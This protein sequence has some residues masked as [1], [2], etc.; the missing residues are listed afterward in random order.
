MFENDNMDKIKT[1]IAG[2]IVTGVSLV[3]ARSW[4]GVIK[5]LVS[6]HVRQIRCKL[7]TNNKEKHKKCLHDQGLMVEFINAG[8]TTLLMAGLMVLFFSQ[9]IKHKPVVK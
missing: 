4:G 9:Y 5:E 1:L 8:V 3:I 7:F 6:R 2:A